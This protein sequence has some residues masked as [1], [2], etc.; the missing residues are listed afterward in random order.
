MRSMSSRGDGGVREVRGV[1]RAW[2]PKRGARRRLRGV[3][4]AWA[5]KREAR[6]RLLGVLAVLWVQA[7]AGAQDDGVISGRVV[8]GATGRP[9]AAAVVTITGSSLIGVQPASQPPRILTGADGRFMFRGLSAGV[10]S[11]VT[12][13]GGYADGEPARRRPGGT[14]PALVLSATERTLDVTV[15]MWTYG[16]IAGS[17]IDEAGEPVVGLQVRALKRADAGGLRRFTIAATTYTDDRG[18]YRFGDLVPAN[19]LVVPCAPPLSATLEA[20]TDVA[21]TG[22]A[23]GKLR[24]LLVPVNVGGAPLAA[25]YGYA[26]PPPAGSRP[27]IYPPTLYPSTASAIAVVSGE[28]RAAN[29][30]LV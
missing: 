8:D 14:A 4:R 1:H 26:I 30:Q 3:L 29:I 20:L 11:V 19:Y 15:P 9:I 13:K 25:S 28:E 18:A 12:T 2:A 5:P 17:V 7:A 21:R 6:R 27:Q 24:A 23:Q 16:A 10:F 22:Q